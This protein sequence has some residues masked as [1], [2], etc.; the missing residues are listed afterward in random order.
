MVLGGRRAGLALGTAVAAGLAACAGG[1]SGVTPGDAF[2]QPMFS[3][4]AGFAANLTL[5]PTTRPIIGVIWTDP[6]ERQPDLVMPASWMSTD[7]PPPAGGINFT[8]R[9]FRPPPPAAVVDVPGANGDHARLA[10]GEIVI[11]DDQDRDGAFRI[12]GASDYVEPP[13]SYLGGTSSV[14]LY[15]ETPFAS[16]Q[17][18]FPLLAAPSP[19]YQAVEFNCDGQIPK[20]TALTTGI[21]FSLQPSSTLPEIRNCDRSH[22]P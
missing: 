10:L 22:S 13:D 15:V 5:P 17:I 2:D 8:M 11:V 12:S 9:V 1:C 19:G 18:K 21:T 7:M 3:V 6:L 20:G 14:L 4:F 16:P